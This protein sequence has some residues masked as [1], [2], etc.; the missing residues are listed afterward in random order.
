MAKCIEIN[1]VELMMRRRE[2]LMRKTNSPGFKEPVEKTFLNYAKYFG[3]AASTLSCSAL[4]RC[5][6]AT[7]R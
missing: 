1:C 6:C 3:N 4:I 2:S 5:R 7:V